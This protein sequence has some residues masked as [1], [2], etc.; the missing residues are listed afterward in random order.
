MRLL[1][2]LRG[3]LPEK[4]QKVDRNGKTL[5]QVCADAGRPV[6]EDYSDLAEIIVYQNG[7][8]TYDGNMN[9]VEFAYNECWNQY[10]SQ[11]TTSPGESALFRS[12]LRYLIHK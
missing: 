2:R 8:P 6:S 11:T 1:Q 3:E 4:P 5:A 10:Y 7:F 12:A 9:D